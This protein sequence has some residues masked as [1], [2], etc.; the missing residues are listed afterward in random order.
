MS[1]LEE[2]LGWSFLTQL[3]FLTTSWWNIA[4]Q[5]ALPQSSH[6]FRSFA[7]NFH[8]PDQLT[9]SGLSPVRVLTSTLASVQTVAVMVPGRSVS[10]MP[11][12]S[13]WKAWKRL[14]KHIKQVFVSVKPA[15]GWPPNRNLTEV[16]ESI[17]LLVNARNMYSTRIAK[18]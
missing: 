10:R 5:N 7:V 17:I 4:T 12:S 16:G 11:R 3:K 1:R 6:H 18:S 13:H 8:S 14:I 9:Y 2:V 15:N